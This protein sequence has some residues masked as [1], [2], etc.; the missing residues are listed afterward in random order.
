VATLPHDSP[1]MTEVIAVHTPGDVFCTQAS[2][3]AQSCSIEQDPPAGT[4]C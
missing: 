1:G 3:Y 2:P 4:G